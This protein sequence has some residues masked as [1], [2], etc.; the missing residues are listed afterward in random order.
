MRSHLAEREN[1]RQRRYVWLDIA[2]SEVKLYPNLAG[3]GTRVWNLKTRSPILTPVSDGIPVTAIQ[4]L[5]SPIHGESLIQATALGELVIWSPSKRAEVASI[6]IL[7]SQRL[8]NPLNQSDFTQIVRRRV[9]D[10][11]EIICL[12]VD[13]SQTSGSTPRF[14]LGM[15]S[16]VIQVWDIDSVGDLSSVFAL[17]LPSTVPAGVAFAGSDARNL[18]VCG[19]YD[20]RM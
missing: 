4:W 10:G 20:G 2:A 11:S 6:Y 9:G 1:A 8:L 16:G 13:T 5:R 17:T 14:A 18:Y 3:D 7:R 15:R 12:A 19:M